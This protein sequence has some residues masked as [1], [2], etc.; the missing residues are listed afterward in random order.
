MEQNE[1]TEETVKAKTA[2]QFNARIGEDLKQVIDEIGRKT[3][4]SKPDLLDEFVRVY[5]TKKADDEFSDMDLT[6]YDNLSNP[7]K[8]SVHN[9][10]EH[11]L[12]AVNGNLSTLKQS[13]I[14]IEEEKRGL[15]DREKEYKTEIEFIKSNSA[16]EF[17]EY[18]EEKEEFEFEM[19]S[20][21][22]LWKDKLIDL[23]ARNIELHKEFDNVNKIAEQV[24]VVT[25][26]NKD[27]RESTRE[28]EAEHKAI[29][30]ELNSHIKS[31]SEELIEAKQL[32]FRAD[33]ES[34]SKDKMIKS[35]KEDLSVEKKERADELSELKEELLSASRELSETQNEY[36]K[37]LGK[38]EVLEK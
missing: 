15:T 1:F 29:Q 37:A 34:D 12:N 24:Q 30:S 5:Q 35:L 4:K 33:L 22:A 38:L 18:K 6:K 11:I 16:K 7:L 8:E 36:N 19:N 10:F 27:L 17:L 31:L 21:I 23:E 25:A 14:H 26:E 13:A 20:Q 9:A 3:G 2:P 28:V 32:V